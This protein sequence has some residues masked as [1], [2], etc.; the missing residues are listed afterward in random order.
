M[1][2]SAL[3]LRRSRLPVLLL[4]WRSSDSCSDFSSLA[5]GSPSSLLL[6]AAQLPE[7]AFD[8]ASGLFGCV[9]HRLGGAFDAASGLFGGVAHCL[10]GA[11]DAASGLFGGVAHCLGGALDAT[12]G[13][14]GRVAHCLGGPLDAASGRRWRQ[15]HRQDSE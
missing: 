6:P 12:S 9:A 14:F 4:S 8:A 13:L 11:F 1:E 2:L 5:V 7:R 15:R 3:L 10:G